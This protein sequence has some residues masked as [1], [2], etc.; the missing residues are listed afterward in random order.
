[1]AEILH[2]IAPGAA[3]A[4]HTASNRL[5]DLA[6]GVIDLSNAGSDIIVDDIFYWGEPFFQNS[7]VAQS[8]IGFNLPEATEAT[9]KVNDVTGRLLKV[10]EGEFAKG[11]NQITLNSGDLGAKGVLSYTVE[12]AEYTATK[13]M[14]VV[15]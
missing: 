7:V 10:I 4:F 3:L 8:I 2:D 11:Y 9:I 6:Q 5:A 15:E 14:I 13:K 1:M 12:T